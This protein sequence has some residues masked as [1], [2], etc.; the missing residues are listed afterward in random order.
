M[1]PIIYCM[2]TVRS[3]FFVRCYPS[4][5][6]T[7]NRLSRR[8]RTEL[9]FLPRWMSGTLTS[10]E[11][12]STNFFSFLQI[13][14]LIE[15][16]SFQQHKTHQQQHQPVL[17]RQLSTSLVVSLLCR[18]NPAPRRIVAG[19]DA[20]SL[21][22]TGGGGGRGPHTFLSALLLISPWVP[23]LTHV[24][25]WSCSGFSSAPAVCWTVADTG[26]MFCCVDCSYS[27]FWFYQFHNNY[28]YY[29]QQRSEGV[30]SEVPFVF[31]HVQ[32]IRRGQASGLKFQI[33]VQ[34]YQ[35][36]WAHLFAQESR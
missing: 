27:L 25:T 5:T 31:R 35:Y 1:L 21:T 29:Q 12:R 33:V 6:C 2:N 10:R 9:W 15:I 32:Y 26:V 20:A 34:L 14:I 7:S 36:F 30:E 8:E 22:S 17:E 24:V 19:T 4:S 13:L 28:S 16:V 11:K 3:F 18:S 23:P